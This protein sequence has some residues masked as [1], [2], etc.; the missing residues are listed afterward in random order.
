MQGLVRVY[1]K[2]VGHRPDFGD[3]VVMSE[4]RGGT[5]WV[6]HLSDRWRGLRLSQSAMGSCLLSHRWRVPPT[7]SAVGAAAEPGAIQAEQKGTPLVVHRPLRLPARYAHTCTL[8]PN[9][10]A[11]P[12]APMSCSRNISGSL[13]RLLLAAAP[14]RPGWLQKPHSLCIALSNLWAR[15]SSAGWLRSVE[16]SCYRLASS[17]QTCAPPES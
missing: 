12:Q 9:P 8:R 5:G 2:K 3:P 10:A 16:H 13:L 14:L 7:S 4:D 6:L 17:P 15:V 1:T 11:T